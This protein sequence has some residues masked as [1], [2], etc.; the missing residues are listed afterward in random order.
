MRKRLRAYGFF[1]E[2]DSPDIDNIPPILTN[3]ARY[4]F[5]KGID[6][7]RCEHL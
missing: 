1:A 3:N 5:V 7:T 4:F 6:F 2:P